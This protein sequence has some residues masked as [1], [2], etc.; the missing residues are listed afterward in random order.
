VVVDEGSIETVSYTSDRDAIVSIER[1]GVP[2]VWRLR[3]NLRSVAYWIATVLIA[4]ETLAGGA[5]DLAH[6]RGLVVAGAPVVDVVTSLGYPV[7]ILT[8]LG[9][10]KLLGGATL[11]A[12]GLP[13]VKEWAYAGI[14]FELTAAAVSLT[15]RGYGVGDIAPPLVLAALA[16]TSWAL[17][18][19][20]RVLGSLL[21][22]RP[23]LPSRELVS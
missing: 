18:P 3:V 20:S 7:Y 5:T 12:P 16:L 23:T 11:L 8:I 14:V 2:D 17:R 21:P 15:V 6:G 22:G 19:P 1:E 10:W 4:A 9:A 13:R